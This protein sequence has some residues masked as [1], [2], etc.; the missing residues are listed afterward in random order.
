M[1]S[2]IETK[3]LLPNQGKKTVTFCKL[4]YNSEYSCQTTGGL[5]RDEQHHP[6]TVVLKFLFLSVLVK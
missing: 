5:R 4:V 2:W 6:N 3:A 1:K